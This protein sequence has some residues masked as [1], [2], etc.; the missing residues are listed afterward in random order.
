MDGHSG[1]AP[2]T[3]G[4]QRSAD[5]TER[6]LGKARIDEG[7]EPS[8]ASPETGLRQEPDKRRACVSGSCDISHGA[9]LLPLS[10]TP[11]QTARAGADRSHREIASS[12]ARPLRAG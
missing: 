8:L 4:E 7:S 12:F 6:K 5:A 9:A 10:T 2:A 1:A 3:V 11:H